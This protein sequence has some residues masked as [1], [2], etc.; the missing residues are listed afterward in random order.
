M[1]A[2]IPIPDGDQPLSVLHRLE[3]VIQQH[4]PD[5]R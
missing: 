4:D 2:L 3:R 5:P 1:P